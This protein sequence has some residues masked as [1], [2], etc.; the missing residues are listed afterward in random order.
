MWSHL[1]K[2][3][4]EFSIDAKFVPQNIIFNHL[5]PKPQHIINFLTLVTKQFI[6]RTKCLNQKITWN[7]LCN[8]FKLIENIELHNAIRSKNIGKHMKK[9]SPIK[10]F[11][12]SI[13]M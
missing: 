13:W 7:K 3:C 10:P 4:N 9:W 11:I 1:Q 12:Q 2:V 5:H 6:F 8:E